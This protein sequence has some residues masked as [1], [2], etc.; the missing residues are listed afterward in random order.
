MHFTRPLSPVGED[1]LGSWGRGI[2]PRRA[3]FNGYLYAA[4]PQGPRPGPPA[5]LAGDNTGV[6][7]MWE[8]E[9]LPQIR[10]ICESIRNRDYEG[11]SAIELGHLLDKLVGDAGQA[12]RLTF[13]P[14]I[15]LVLATNALV[16][17]CEK[18]LGPGGAVHAVTMLQGFENESA[19]AGAGLSR[20]AE[21]AETQPEVATAIR[22]SRFDDIRD[23]DKGEVF[24]AEMEH[25]LD[26]YGW[27][28][29]TWGEI[30]LP[31]WA[32][33]SSVPL[34]LIRRYLIDP[35]HSP[36]TAQRR[37]VEQREESI[38]HAESTLA[39]GK[40]DEF[41]ELL[42]NAQEHVPVSEGRAQWQLISIGTLRVPLLSL[43][44]K[45]IHAGVIDTAED[46]F[47]LRL[48]ELKELAAGGGPGEVRSTVSARRDD[49]ERWGRLIP[50]R[51][52]GQQPST[53]LA[54]PL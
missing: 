20:L 33:E 2:G 49:L 9:S 13:G 19:A 8:H 10:E 38:R 24:L 35:E 25:Y 44:H 31:T 40:L 36:P 16:D 53:E 6:R 5:G 27:R 23:A 45:L 42:R 51:S 41:R 21:L 48:E 28:A 34:G 54:A 47:Y 1:I 52:L 18:E 26:E 11:V 3:V 37:A 22:D 30:H 29:V 43:G 4:M 7:E 15:G 14:F 46:V 50:P 32:E 12:F 39:A 17:F